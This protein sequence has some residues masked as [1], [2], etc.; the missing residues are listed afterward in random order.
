MKLQ[1]ERRKECRTEVGPILRKERR[2]KHSNEALW[3]EYQKECRKENLEGSWDEYFG[4]N[5]G[6]NI[7]TKLRKKR[8]ED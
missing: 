5:I 1:K 2:E 6:R 8:R 7:T 4:K 3:K